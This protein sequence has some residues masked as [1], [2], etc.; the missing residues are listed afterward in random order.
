MRILNYL[1]HVL[2][3][4]LFLGIAEDSF[5]QNS[6]RPIRKP[7]KKNKKSIVNNLP[8]FFVDDSQLPPYLKTIYRRDAARISLRLINKELRL[9]QQTIQIPEELVQ[10]VYNALV[11]VRTSDYGVIDTIAA[12]HNVRTFPVPNVEKIILVAEYDSPWLAPLNQRQDTTGSATLNNIIREHQLV[13]SQLVRIDEERT[14][15]VLQSTTP[16]N[17]PALMMQFFIQEG[18]GSIEEVLPFGDG[19]DIEI[20]RTKH[21]WD[22]TYS[23]R[24]GDC[25]NQCQKYHNWNFTVAEDGEVSYHGSSGHTIPPWIKGSKATSKL[26]PDVLRRR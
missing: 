3:L 17:I 20:T 15:L 23:V 2:L 25:S 26:P 10:A 5:A 8:P 21:G 9:S 16:I 7:K 14:A 6:R 4:I 19:N 22:L 24:F 1:S 13:L 18:I 12:Q 11:A